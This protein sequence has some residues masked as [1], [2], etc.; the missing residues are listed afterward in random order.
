MRNNVDL[1]WLWLLLLGLAGLSIV[2]V[3]EFELFLLV[4][5]RLFG[6]KFLL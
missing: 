1:D 4:C 6:L 2:W 3:L 5:R